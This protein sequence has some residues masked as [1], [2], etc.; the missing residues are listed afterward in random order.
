MRY[1]LQQSDLLA[2]AERQGIETRVHGNE[3]QFKE[4]PYCHSSRGDRWSFSINMESGAFRCPRA[5]CGRQGHFVELARDFDFRLQADDTGAFKSL[6]QI[7]LITSTPAEQYLLHRGIKKEVTRAY[8][9]TTTKDDSN[10]LIFPFYRP[11]T[12]T[13]GNRYNKLEFVKYRLIDYDK[14][15]HKSKEWCE[16]GC[17]P[18]LFGMDHCDPTKNKTLV[19]TEGQIDSLSLASAGIPNAVS[20]PT[21]ARGFTWVEH[22]RDFVEQFDTIVV[23]GDHERGSITL[24]KEIR[25]LFPKCKVRS[26][27]PG[28]YLL[29]KDA[30]DILQAYGEQAL[31]HAVEQAE[32]FQPPTIKDMANVQGIALNDVP[33]FKTMLP[34]LDQTIGGFYEGQLIALTGKCGTG[35]S[36]LASMFAVAALWQDWNVLVYSGELAD[37]EVKRWMDFQIAGE[38]AIKER[39][40]TDSAGFYLDTEQEQQLADWYRH[41]L[42]IVDNLALAEKDNMDIVSEIEAAARAY[43]VRFVLVDNLMTAI[44]EGTDMYIEQSKFVKKLKLLASKL[45]IVILLVAHPK[46]TKSRELDVD[47]ISGSGNIGNLSDTVIMLDRDTTT[48]DDG[49]KITRTLLAVKKNRATGILLQEDDRIQLRHSRKSKR[50]YQVGDKGICQF[51]FNLD[52]AKKEVTKLPF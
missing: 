41:R 22:C 38:K 42:F 16:S 21:G 8:G 48:K 40:Y 13:S 34:K 12:D 35:K 45:Q 37:Y 17:R 27:R 15:K 6:P 43:D 28:D 20:V 32:V 44:A 51:P 10:Q 50:L 11:V 18:I 31:H 52:T 30:N 49:E 26:V 19:I 47:E 25:E 1:Q 46:K 4:C 24:V 23:F 2:F 3:L 14:T 36:T 9:I 5:S 7:R 33:H 39:V 29:E